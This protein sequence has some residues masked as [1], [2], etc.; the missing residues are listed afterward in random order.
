MH[1]LISGASITGPALAWWLH[2]FG[3]AATLVEKAPAPVP[4]GHAVDVRGAAMDVLRAMGLEPAAAARRTTMTGMSILDAAGNEVWR[5]EEMTL[6]GGSFGK[7]AIEILRDDIS[8][9]LVS[10]LPADV[11]LLYGDSIVALDEQPDGILVTFEHAAPRRFDLVVGADGIRSN[12]R[13]LAFGPD[14]E[15]LRPFGLALA[16]FSVPNT[17]G[18]ADWQ[19]QY[20]DGADNCLV[21]T[22][23]DNRELRVCFGFAASPDDVAVNRAGQMALVRDRCGH[24]GWKVPEFL[25]AMESSPDFYVGAIAQVKMP[26]WTRGRVALCGDAGYCPS[27]FTGQGT[28]LA[29]VGAHV[30]ARELARTPDAIA[31][32]FSRY[33]TRMRPFVE[34][35]QAIADLTRDERFA[36]PAY[37]GDVVEPAMDAAVSAIDLDLLEPA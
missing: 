21:Y 4:G 20:R 22:A 10:A 25:A 11:E 1:V 30:L 3:I 16:P 13:A 36:D 23:R 9:V 34:K 2:R 14:R 37:Y 26:G 35:N 5:S 15:F 24:L 17:L 31:A 19:V 12:V 18:I 6:S 8:G 32:A 33:E 27:P 7:D 28:S 29:F